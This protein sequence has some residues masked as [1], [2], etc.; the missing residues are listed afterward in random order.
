MWCHLH[1]QGQRNNDEIRMSFLPHSYIVFPWTWLLVIVCSD[2]RLPVIAMHNKKGID[3]CQGIAIPSILHK[4][5]NNV[6]LSAQ[7]QS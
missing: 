5:M 1:Q 6:Q 4:T 2:D 7:C 3:G